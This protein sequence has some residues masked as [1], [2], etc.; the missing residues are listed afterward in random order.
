[1]AQSMGIEAL[2]QNPPVDI[3]ILVRHRELRNQEILF[4]HTILG[5][6]LVSL[7]MGVSIS[8]YFSTGKGRAYGW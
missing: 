6:L 4:G 8:G 1:M 2:C 7:R 5:D 3:R